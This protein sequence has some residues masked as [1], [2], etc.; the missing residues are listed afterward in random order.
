M[1]DRYVVIGH[2]IAHSKSPAIHRAFA[3][4]T[5]QDLRY[6]TLLS[7]LDD[8]AGTW[9]AFRAA[10]GCGANVTVPFK[11]EAWAL[12]QQLSF[13]ARLAGAVN[14]LSL[15]AT[16][17]LLGDNTDGLGLVQDICVNASWPLANKRVLLLGAGG[18]ARGVIQPLLAAGVSTLWIAN[19]S[20]E[21]AQTLAALFAQE[22]SVQALALADLSQIR[23]PVDV[24][25]NA[26]SASLHGERLAIPGSL[27]HTDTA[28][29]DMMYGRDTAFLQWAHEQ[30]I[31]HRRDGLGMLVEQAAEAFFIW[32]GIRPHTQEIL[33]ALRLEQK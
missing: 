8:F 32:R 26:T 3:E 7:P 18:A 29:Y 2:P 31:Q 24:I 10:G 16:G 14:T 19:R 15:T 12:C 33:R 27:I 4:Q 23:E 11:E 13:R 25:I 28:A 17:E 1:T 22:G 30:G 6:D 20:V 21:K 9:Q 5:G